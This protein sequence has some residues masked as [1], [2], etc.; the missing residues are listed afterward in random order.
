MLKHKPDLVSKSTTSASM[1]LE[2]RFE[3]MMKNCELILTSN[4]KLK[5]QNE[6]FRLQLGEKTKLK[7]KQKGL[8]SVPSSDQDIASN[9]GTNSW[10]PFVRRS[11][12]GDQ[13]EKRDNLTLRIMRLRFQSLKGSLILMNS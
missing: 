3:A 6:R 7:L 2:E 5:N 10:N 8:A 13:E 4:E 9:K 1:S 11:V 12:L